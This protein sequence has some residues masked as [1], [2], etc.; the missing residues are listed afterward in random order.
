MAHFDDSGMRLTGRADEIKQFDVRIGID[1]VDEFRKCAAVAGA[2]D[3]S[4]PA[5][6]GCCR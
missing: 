5:G 3:V 6:A 1:T 2:N 4:A